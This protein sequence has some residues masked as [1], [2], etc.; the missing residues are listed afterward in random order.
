MDW[1]D[2]SYRIATQILQLDF[3]GTFSVK[4]LEIKSLTPHI[5][6]N[7]TEETGAYLYHCMLVNGDQFEI[8]YKL[9]KIF[10]FF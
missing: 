8:K 6:Q 5:L 7:V 9:Q 3:T 1:K 2:R 4:L 10:Y